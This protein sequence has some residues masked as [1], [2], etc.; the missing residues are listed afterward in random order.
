MS[1]KTVMPARSSATHGYFLWPRWRRAVGSSQVKRDRSLVPSQ[2]GSF[3]EVCASQPRSGIGTPA[4]LHGGHDETERTG[5][6][7]PAESRSAAV[8]PLGTE[9]FLGR[10]VASRERQRPEFTTTPSAHPARV[11]RA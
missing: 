9:R 2:R 11:E 1:R 3:S 8:T 4:R 10:D 7:F 6:R 5:S